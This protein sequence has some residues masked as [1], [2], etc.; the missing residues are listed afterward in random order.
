MLAAGQVGLGGLQIGLL[1]EAAD[2]IG[3]LALGVAAF[4]IAV[5][6]FRVRRQD[7][8][9]HQLAVLGQRDRGTD[10]G[11]ER[12]GV[13]DQVISGEDQQQRVLRFAERLQ[14]DQCY[15]RRG[16]AANRFEHDAGVVHAQLAQLLGREETVFLVAD[17][18]RQLH[19]QAFQALDGRLQHRQ[20]ALTEVEE[21]LRIE[22][23]RKR[24]QT[25]TAT[26][27]HDHWN[28]C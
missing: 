23:T 7:A 17:Q 12:R 21:L 10:A 3:A 22:L 20:R 13:L 24:P 19:V 1:D 27:G 14:G 9:G 5:A 4:Q 16:V 2:R 11:V 25:R 26:T 28:H 8:E 6:G 18:P 15:R